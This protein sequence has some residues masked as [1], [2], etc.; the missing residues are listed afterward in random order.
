MRWYSK[1]KQVEACTQK[2]CSLHHDL[3]SRFSSYLVAGLLLQLL[4]SQSNVNAS[5]EQK[6]FIVSQSDLWP[7]RTDLFEWLGECNR[8][9]SSPGSALARASSSARVQHRWGEA[10]LPRLVPWSCPKKDQFWGKADH[11]IAVCCTSN[12]KW[13]CWYVSETTVLFS[14]YSTL[15]RLCWRHCIDTAPRWRPFSE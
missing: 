6:Y 7:D 4:K 5:Y 10:G 9:S 14:H 2:Q 11:L 15:S 12:V 3:T 13:L 8:A 1:L